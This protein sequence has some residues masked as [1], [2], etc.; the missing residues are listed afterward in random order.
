MRE[1]QIWGKYLGRPRR[2]RSCNLG[3][4]GACCVSFLS[5]FSAPR[6]P[7]RWDFLSIPALEDGTFKINAP[8]SL[9]DHMTNMCRGRCRHRTHGLAP[10]H[11]FLADHCYHRAGN[12]S[13]YAWRRCCRVQP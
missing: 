7:S 10:G 4:Y 13:R 12:H 11:V 3:L 9:P 1:V 2:T 6:P 5:V 8:F